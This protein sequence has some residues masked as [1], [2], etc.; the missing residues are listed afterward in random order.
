MNNFLLLFLLFYTY[1]IYLW[2]FKNRNATHHMESFFDFFVEKDFKFILEH[3]G[4]DNIKK[5]IHKRIKKSIGATFIICLVLNKDISINYLIFYFILGI[6]FYKLQYYLIKKKYEKKLLEADERFPYYLNNLCILIQN[7]SVPVAL[8]KS[9]DVAP[10]LFKKDLEILVSDIHIGHKKGLIPYLEFNNKF[11]QVKDLNRVVKTLFNISN[12]ST[13]KEKMVMSLA[14]ITNERVFN[15]RK[16]Y[17][18]KILDKQALIPWI[19]F[20][21]V[22]IVLIASFSGISFGE[23]LS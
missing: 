19:S 10:R 17:F 13:S 3:L 1:M 9:I 18:N 20:L 12:A 8:N 4:E 22:G 15:A 7:N 2:F 14:K 23:F 21:W 11:K 16:D 5:V 6:L